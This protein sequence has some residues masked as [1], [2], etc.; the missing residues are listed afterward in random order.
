MLSHFLRKLGTLGRPA[1]SLRLG[2][3]R[4]VIAP[5]AGGFVPDLDRWLADG[6][7]TIVKENPY[8]T[9]YRAVL[10]DGA[11]FVKR[12]R[13][14]GFRAWWREVLRPPKAR[15][16]FD[17]ALALL[18]RG[19]P[20]ARPLAWGHAAGVGP[21]ESVLATRELPGV[22]F[23]DSARD[24]TPR[25]R[26]RL[27]VALGRFFARLHDA[28][29]AHPDPHPG[30]FLVDA[31]PAFALLD[32]H[33]VRLGR[34][35]PWPASRD[36]L[37]VLNRYFQLRA[38]RA[39]RLRFWRAYL[40]E[41][42]ALFRA[43]GGRQPPVLG[44]TGIP[45]CVPHQGAD[46]PR[47]PGQRTD[48]ARDLEHHTSASNL[49]FWAG[50]VG[51][52]VG[53]NR[54]FRRL[55]AG[56]VRGWAVRDLPEEFLREFLADPAAMFRRPG[57]RLLKDSRTSTVAAFEMTTPAG[58]RAVVLKRVNVRRWPEPVKN[59]LRPSAVV[60]SWVNGH[61]LRDRWLPTPRP[62]AAAH[63][64]R[65]GLPAEGYLL[66]ELVPGA[67]ELTDA[68][69]D[70]PAVADRLA[71]LVRQMHDRHVSHRDLKAANVLLGGGTTPT[72]IDLVGVRV[73]RPVPFQQRAKELA[74]LSASFLASPR[75]RHADR[76]RFLRAYLA[77]GERRPEG[78]KAWWRAVAAATA[79]K[80]R[81]NRRTGRPLA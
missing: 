36:N 19:V 32:V 10:P 24:L 37:V 4:W 70:L 68:V 42:D 40:A 59:L 64:Y 13:V 26:R 49:R 60:R 33:A 34:P 27:A 31:G 75:V 12:C 9:V 8:R 2:G 25:D 3:R 14:R 21:R 76:L 1:A 55:R 71:R 18:D 77:A 54:H 74:R 41:R 61:T 15:L 57:V 80:V 50:R 28:G 58:P 30:N 69:P 51:R 16:E 35:L 56:P 5:D 44:G 6:L 45:A 62:L 65:H 79:T 22:P 63:V 29:V 46:A 48:A 73:G 17:T 67:V 11:V 72:L 66:T 38:S 39:D 53:K 47:S 78:W 52:C 23:V 43:S 20:T 81:K 7:A